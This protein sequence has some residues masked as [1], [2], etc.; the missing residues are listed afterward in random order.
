MGDIIHLESYRAS[1]QPGTKRLRPKPSKGCSSL[2]QNL[3][4]GPWAKHMPQANTTNLA[5]PA[6]H[7]IV[8]YLTA[9]EALINECPS[10]LRLR[11]DELN[12]M[13]QNGSEGSVPKDVWTAP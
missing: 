8:L 7:G 4:V 5:K 1:R 9:R 12:A 2:T 3:G 11:A 10:T 6:Q 13:G